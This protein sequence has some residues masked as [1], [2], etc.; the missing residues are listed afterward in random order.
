MKGRKWRDKMKLNKIFL[1]IWFSRLISIVGT[2]LTEFGVSVWLFDKTG[3]ATPMAISILCAV[4]PAIIFSPISGIITDRFSKKRIMLIADTCAA[5]A[6][7]ILAVLCFFNHLNVLYV[8]IFSFLSATANLF[9]NIAYQASITSLVKEEEVK[10]AMGYNQIIDSLSGLFA[11]ILA[12]ILYSFIG[13]KGIIGIDISTYIISMIFFITVPSGAFG[14][15]EEVEEKGIKKQSFFE[16]ISQGFQFI[17]SQKSLTLLMIFFALLNFLFN[18][19]SVLIEPLSLSIGN[20]I[21][22]GLVKVSSGIGL[23]AGSFFITLIK[24]KVPYSKGIKYAVLI[25][26]FAL[27]VMGIRN[28]I[29]CIAIGR[30]IFCFVVPI[31]NT[32][33]GTLWLLRTPKELQGRVFAS[34]MMV[35]RSIMP[36]SYLMVGP[37]VDYVLPSWI[38]KDTSLT[39]LIDRT[40]GLELFN[41]RII[42]LFSGVIIMVASYLFFA[43]NALKTIGDFDNNS[44]QIE[45]AS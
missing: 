16:R 13:L 32:L 26:G 18:L 10:T 41:Y 20:S 22:L 39:Q 29:I 38:H 8:Y 30:I 37:L 36:L 4:L 28:S 9:D 45:K 14:T 44:C 15:I 19:T 25:A 31:A 24:T 43:M 7:V 2:G 6:T 23:M 3:Q 17:F 42:F 27:V 35:V 34:R 1:R 33:A 12:G 21:A 11:P 5:I 40:L